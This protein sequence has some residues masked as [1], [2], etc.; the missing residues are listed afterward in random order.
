MDALL[1]PKV[2]SLPGHIQAV[3]VQSICKLYSSLMNKAEKEV[4]APAKLD[5]VHRHICS[6]LRYFILHYITLLYITLLNFTL[7][8]IT[9]HYFALQNIALL[10]LHYITLLYI[11]LHYLTLLYITSFHIML[12]R[13]AIQ[14]IIVHEHIFLKNSVVLINSFSS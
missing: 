1:K 7:H 8:Y 12:H 10:Q 11:T 4:C 5:I 13:V 3:Y 2:T 9:L 14:Y 6:T